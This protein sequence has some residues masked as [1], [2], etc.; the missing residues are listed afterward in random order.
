M[1]PL[2]LRDGSVLYSRVSGADTGGTRTSS[3]S[4]SHVR[5]RPDTGNLRDCLLGARQWRS[6]GVGYFLWYSL[7]IGISRNSRSLDLR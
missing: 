3:L 6:A 2:Y 7:V 4:S 1:A 5:A